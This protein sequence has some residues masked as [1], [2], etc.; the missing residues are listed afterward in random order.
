MLNACYMSVVGSLKAALVIQ[1]HLLIC[2]VCAVGSKKKSFIFSA[3]IRN[4][5]AATARLLYQ[6][7]SIISATYYKDLTIEP[8]E[9][10]W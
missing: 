2:I 1:K 3:I 8:L 10:Q 4:T 9:V 7:Y 6:L 5:Q